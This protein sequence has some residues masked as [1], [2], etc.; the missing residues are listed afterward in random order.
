MTVNIKCD[1]IYWYGNPFCSE[2]MG[3]PRWLQVQ[4]Q[5]QTHL[6]PTIYIYNLLCMDKHVKNK[7]VLT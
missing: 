1:V 2:V 4:P 3:I 6:K 7:H 5:L